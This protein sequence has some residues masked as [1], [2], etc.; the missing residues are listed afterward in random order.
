MNNARI[1]TI[2][3]A[4]LCCVVKHISIFM[5]SKHK[6]YDSLKYDQ[7]IY[8]LFPKIYSTTNKK[9]LNPTVTSHILIM[10]ILLKE[11]WYK[12][13]CSKTTIQ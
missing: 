5:S 9:K 13:T 2:G 10:K 7:K 6:N 1:T 4:I 3:A 8:I 12:I 11:E